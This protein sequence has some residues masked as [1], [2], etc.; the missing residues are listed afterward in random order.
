MTTTIRSIVLLA[1]LVLVD[2]PAG[3]QSGAAQAQDG[4]LAATGT[5][6]GPDA[7]PQAGVPLQVQGPLGQTHVFTGKDGTWSL[8]NLPPGK[9]EV[10]PVDGAT[11]STNKTVGFTVKDAGFFDK[12]TGGTQKAVVVPQ[13]TVDRKF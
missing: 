2:A 3:A 4:S 6:L 7:A 8:Y 12:L 10:K 9:Y 1:A 11:T 5:V 13:I